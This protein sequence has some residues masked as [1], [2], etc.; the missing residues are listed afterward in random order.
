MLL[1]TALIIALLVGLNTT[2]VLKMYN[3]KGNS[4]FIRQQARQQRRELSIKIVGWFVIG[5]G[6]IVGAGM[7]YAFAV[8]VLAMG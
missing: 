8:V 7:F 4:A 5:C 6:A 1:L 3:Y 2:E